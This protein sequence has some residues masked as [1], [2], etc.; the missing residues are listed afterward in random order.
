MCSCNNNHFDLQYRREKM[1][2]DYRVQVADETDFPALTAVVA[3]CFK[4]MP[5]EQLITGSHT[6]SNLD[7]LAGRYLHA[8][9]LHQE[10]HN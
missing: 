7:A 10:R 9:R 5:V 4:S 3:T 8:H 6:Q 2:G 1:P